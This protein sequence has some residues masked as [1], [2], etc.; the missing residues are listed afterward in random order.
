MG[1]G[2]RRQGAA[3]ILAGG[4]SDLPCMPVLCV[5]YFISVN[6]HMISAMQFLIR[7]LWMMKTMEKTLQW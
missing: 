1:K 5:L 6:L 2:I 7:F 3:S 4:F